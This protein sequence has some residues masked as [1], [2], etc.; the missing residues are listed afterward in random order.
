MTVK[1]GLLA[2]GKWSVLAR[3]RGGKPATKPNATSA[4]RLVERRLKGLLEQGETA[5]YVNYGDG[6]HNES[7]T[8]KNYAELMFTFTH[9]MEDYLDRYFLRQRLGK[10]ILEKIKNKSRV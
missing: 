9:F 10:Y 8:S 6:G 5:V 3:K 4:Y 7:V 2:N 1:V